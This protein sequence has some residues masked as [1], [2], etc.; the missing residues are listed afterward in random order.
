M[1]FD[2][3]IL[4]AFADGELDPI[5]AKRVERAIASD[6]A[7]AAT[8]AKH[9]LL[10][11]T[12]TD[13][14]PLDGRPDPLAD[15]IRT[16]SVVTMPV[17]AVRG[18]PVWLQ[19]AAL[20]A[21]LVAGVAVGTQ[22][23]NG[24]VKSTRGALVASGALAGALETRIATASGDTRMLVSFR[25]SGGNYCRVFASDAVDGI[26]CKKDGNWDLVQTRSGT[27]RAG[28]AYRQVGSENVALMAEA[29][30]MMAGAPLSVADETRARALRWTPECRT[31][32][33]FQA[34]C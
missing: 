1:T 21:C 17:K 32:H 13:A 28:T 12:L 6:P 25:D 16:N 29:Q 23:Q 18:R 30:D 31:A 24:P 27:T 4:M 2:D 14:Y 11:Q 22:W 5:A 20:A 33:G 26:A 7:L 34:P 3:E 15:L 8:V 10:R 9:R 19:A